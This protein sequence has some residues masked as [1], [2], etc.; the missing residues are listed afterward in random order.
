MKTSAE[1]ELRYI[2][3]SVCWNVYCLFVTLLG[4][5]S[6]LGLK[7]CHFV[8]VKTTSTLNAFYFR[9]EPR[10]HPLPP[11]FLPLLAERA[12]IVI[13]AKTR[14]H[15]T[16]RKSCQ[17]RYG[18][19]KNTFTAGTRPRSP[20]H[21]RRR[22]RQRRRRHS[23]VPVHVRSPFLTD[24]SCFPTAVGRRSTENARA[25]PESSRIAVSAVLPRDES[26]HERA[27]G[28]S[29]RKCVRASAMVRSLAHW[30]KTLSFPARISPNKASKESVVQVCA[31]G[32]PTVTP[33]P[34]NNSLAKNN[35]INAMMNNGGSVSS[36][37]VNHVSR[38]RAE[39][40]KTAFFVREFIFRRIMSALRFFNVDLTTC[41]LR[42]G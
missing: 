11:V 40:G 1:F 22:R 7:D 20:R 29:P 28:G 41:R 15:P 18:C 10:T 17:R 32:S 35:E 34:S 12:R 8:R 25:A 27:H 37:D 24:N 6:L 3:V 21:R 39:G 38:G 26:R 9:H 30:T 2:I 19:R 33:T 36:R 16:E 31:G 42:F 5:E 13:T 23:T 14:E 4:C